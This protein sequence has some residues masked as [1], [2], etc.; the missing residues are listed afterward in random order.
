MA[1]FGHLGQPAAGFLRAMLL[2]R[3]LMFPIKAQPACSERLP[4]QERYRSALLEGG[5]AQ[6]IEGS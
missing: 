5:D 2:Q 3:R 6:E 1:R 4:A